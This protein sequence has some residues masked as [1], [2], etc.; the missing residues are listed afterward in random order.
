MQFPDDVRCILH[1]YLVNSS[2]PFLLTFLKSAALTLKA[3]NN[4]HC[5]AIGL[6]RRKWHMNSAWHSPAVITPAYPVTWITSL[7]DQTPGVRLFS[8]SP[9]TR[10][11]GLRP[12]RPVPTT[13]ASG[14]RRCAAAQR[15]ANTPK[16]GAQGTPS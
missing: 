16:E 4:P 15:C 9:A 8:T 11:T 10:A 2:K 3:I 12:R 7:C 13:S 6:L 14:I 1:K 5:R